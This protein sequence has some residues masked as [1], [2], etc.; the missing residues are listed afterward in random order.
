MDFSRLKLKKLKKLAAY[1][2]VMIEIPHEY[3]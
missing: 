2:L 3:S 1:Y